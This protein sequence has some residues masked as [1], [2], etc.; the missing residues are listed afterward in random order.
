M[1]SIAAIVV[2]AAA[3]V[4]ATPAAAASPRITRCLAQHAKVELRSTT[5]QPGRIGPVVRASFANGNQVGLFFYASATRA[6][7]ELVRAKITAAA[8]HTTVGTIGAVLYTWDS[9]PTKA[10]TRLVATCLR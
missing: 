10:Q 1:K 2:T 8:F 4:G 6:K 7:V 3:L 9:K 5:H